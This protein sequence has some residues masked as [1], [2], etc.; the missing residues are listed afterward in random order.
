MALVDLSDESRQKIG[1]LLYQY[2]TAGIDVQGRAPKW[3]EAVERQYRNEAPDSPLGPDGQDAGYQQFHMPLSQP[4]LDMLAAQVC[5]VICK[6]VPVMMDTEDDE[7]VA[8]AR[9]RLGH[10]VWKDAGFESRIRDAAAITGCTD[11]AYIR[12]TPSYANRGAVEMDV[13]HPDVV[14]VFPALP[15]G[16]QA[17]QCVGHQL[18]M[19][20]FVCDSMM[21]S[22]DYYKVENLGASSQDESD[23]DSEQRHTGTNLGETS[24]S[25]DAELIEVWPCVVRLNLAKIEDPESTV[26]E[27]KLY[28]ASLD[29]KGAQLLKLEEYGFDYIPYFRFRFIGSP[30]YFYSGQSV[31][32][33]LYGIQDMYNSLWSGFFG[34]AMQAASGGPVVGEG[35]TD[36]EKYKKF[37]M[38]SIIEADSPVQPWQGAVRFDGQPFPTMIAACERV[39]DQVSRISQNTQ[40]AQALGSTTAT[41]QSIIAAGVATGIEQYISRFSEDLP[42]MMSLTMQIIADDYNG[43]A[44]RYGKPEP[45]PLIGTGQLPLTP[46]F[47]PP[48]QSQL[49]PIV[50]IPGLGGPAQPEPAGV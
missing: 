41:E 29:F 45:P 25:R 26:V 35:L 27:E 38:F 48:A 10:D 33:N 20:R 2:V 47:P 50:P 19:R 5:T 4:R 32:R 14:S 34:G 3:W 15:Q 44:Q 49:P 11:L 31:G 13:I 12:L 9:Q 17:A 30:R 7:N 28:W 42:A 1:R 23:I 16:I 37:G 18:F 8:D 36:G 39:A 24:P 40:G 21:D 22:G 43:Y 6:Q 46:D